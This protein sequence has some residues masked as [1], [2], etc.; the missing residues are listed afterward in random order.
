MVVVRRS[1][2]YQGLNFA[3]VVEGPAKV[4]LL[5]ANRKFTN[6]NLVVAVLAALRPV[7]FPRSYATLPNDLVPGPTV[8]KAR[9]YFGDKVVPRVEGVAVYCLDIYN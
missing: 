7:F 9:K 1:H 8:Y 6:T 3:T 5:R 4:S 2:L